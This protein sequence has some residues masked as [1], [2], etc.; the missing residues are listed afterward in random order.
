[1]FL[2]NVSFVIRSKPGFSYDPGN[3]VEN[4]N[5]A[6]MGKGGH[7]FPGLYRVAGKCKHVNR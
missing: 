5:G 7:S 2:E 4:E 6:R 3:R 1:M